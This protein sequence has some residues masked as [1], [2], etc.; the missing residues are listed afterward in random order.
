LLIQPVMYNKLTCQPTGLELW[1]IWLHYVRRQN[2]KTHIS[3]WNLRVSEGTRLPICWT[4]K[5]QPVIQ[6][7]K[8]KQKRIN[9]EQA[10]IFQHARWIILRQ[11]RF[12]NSVRWH[13][14]SIIQPHVL[15]LRQH[16]IEKLIS[17]NSLSSKRSTEQL[18]EETR[19]I[20]KQ[21]KY[22]SHV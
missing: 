4:R 14:F 8:E 9:I 16:L 18:T 3:G 2:A 13:S 19:H 1:G 20:F 11:T 21:G 22:V 10:Q 7:K 17:K 5:K 12:I 6:I 15:K